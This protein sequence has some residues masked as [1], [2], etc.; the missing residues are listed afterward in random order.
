MPAP[1]SPGS[2]ITLVFALSLCGGVARA[3][4]LSIQKHSPSAPPTAGPGKATR[5]T[6]APK[7]LTAY[8]DWVRQTERKRAALGASIDAAKSH[9]GVIE[10]VRKF[11]RSLAARP[12][13]IPAELRAVDQTYRAAL[14]REATQAIG[15]LS[16]FSTRDLARA[17][18]YASAGTRDLDQQLDTVRHGL[19]GAGQR[20]HLDKVPRVAP[21]GSGSY[22]GYLLSTLPE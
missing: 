20:H 21:S 6:S 11:Q 17:R 5:G 22:Y 4:D 19:R 13:S 7:A 18:R 15:L 1:R 3:A 2:L 8:L 12:A 16:S 10:Q 14:T 9:V